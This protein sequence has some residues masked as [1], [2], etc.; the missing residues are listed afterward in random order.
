MLFGKLSRAFAGGTN[1]PAE[2]TVAVVRFIRC[3]GD[4]S[5]ADGRIA[6]RVDK[7]DCLS[8]PTLYNDPPRPP[9]IAYWPLSPHFQFGV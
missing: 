4:A 9:A 1:F 7:Q 3:S 2:N 5:T 8:H 6:I